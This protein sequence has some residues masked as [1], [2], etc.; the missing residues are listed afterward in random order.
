[1]NPKN[2][3]NAISRFLAEEDGSTA[4]EYAVML[5]AILAVCIAAVTFMGNSNRESF[6]ASSAAISG[7]N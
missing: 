5:G 7:A 4:V 6:E 2:V 1:M 3:W